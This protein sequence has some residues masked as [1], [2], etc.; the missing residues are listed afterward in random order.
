MQPKVNYKLFM[1][2]VDRKPSLVIQMRDHNNF[3][4][5]IKQGESF[6][7]LK[8]D[9]QYLSANP[10]TVLQGINDYVYPAMNAISN[11]G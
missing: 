5:I 3:E 4:F 7:D 8:G 6:T 1:K 2:L 11:V 10:N 9:Y